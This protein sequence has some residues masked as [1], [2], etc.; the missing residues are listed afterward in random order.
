MKALSLVGIVLA[1]FLIVLGLTSKRTAGSLSI[2][3]VICGVLLALM[4]GAVQVISFIMKKKE[5]GSSD[6]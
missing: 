3:V 2:A 4:V 6:L 5:N 1:A